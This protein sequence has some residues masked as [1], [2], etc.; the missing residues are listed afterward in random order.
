[1]GLKQ[2]CSLKKCFYLLEDNSD[3]SN[4]FRVNVCFF[5]PHGLAAVGGLRRKTWCLMTC[6]LFPSLTAPPL[7]SRSRGPLV[8]AWWRVGKE[9]KKIFLVFWHFISATGGCLKSTCSGLSSCSC[10]CFGAL[11]VTLEKHS[12]TFSLQDDVDFFGGPFIVLSL[13]LGLV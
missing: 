12:N 2:F 8:F 7:S 4:F 6:S 5:S 10:R 3:N 1:M 9:R 11:E 13:L